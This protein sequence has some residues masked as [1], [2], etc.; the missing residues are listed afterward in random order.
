M[1]NLKM[2][3]LWSG[4]D[5]KYFVMERSEREAKDAI[6]KKIVDRWSKAL[7]VRQ[8]YFNQCPEEHKKALARH[9]DELAGVNKCSVQVLGQGEV[10]EL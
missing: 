2:F 6:R 7:P 8:N 1:K 4:K 9:E 10:V 3:Y 5:I